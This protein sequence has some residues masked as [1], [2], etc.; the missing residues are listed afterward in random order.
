M[1]DFPNLVKVIDYKARKCRVS[2]K[3]NPKRPTPRHIITKI[4]KWKTERIL[5]ASR[6]KQLSYLQ[7]NSHKN[8]S[9][10]LNRNIAGQKELA[11]SIQ[12][13][14]NK[15]PIT[16]IAQQSYHLELKGR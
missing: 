9:W 11:R 7:G 15:V 12:S 1:E 14:E 8:V 4:P 6:E 3:M 13:D 5:K 2:N 16:K 10:F